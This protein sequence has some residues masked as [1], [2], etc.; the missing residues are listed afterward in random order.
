MEHTKTTVPAAVVSKVLVAKHPCFKAPQADTLTQ[1][2][3]DLIQNHGFTNVVT[4]TSSTAKDFLPRLAAKHLAQPVTD[5][6]AVD[7][8]TLS[9]P[10]YAGNAVTKVKSKDKVKFLSLRPTNFEEISTEG[11]KVADVQT[12]DVANL[13]PFIHHVSDQV[14]VSDKPD[15]KSARFVVSGGRALGSKENFKLLEDLADVMGSTAIGASR[16]AV[17]AGYAPND[18]QVG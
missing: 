15:L 6:V 11:A 17:D 8:E 9:R 3:Q 18:Q 5:I 14:T 12:V 4:S 2:L 16:A 1:L 13:K 7:K 10:V